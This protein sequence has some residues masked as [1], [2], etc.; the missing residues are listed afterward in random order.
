MLGLSIH[1]RLQRCKN[2]AW[3]WPRLQARAGWRLG[4]TSRSSSSGAADAEAAIWSPGRAAA[5]AARKASSD[6]RPAAWPACRSGGAGTGAGGKGGQVGGK[7]G[8]GLYLK[9][10]EQRDEAA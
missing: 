1:I 9:C 2:H 10:T 6:G 4:D 8:R 7:G 5:A 3:F